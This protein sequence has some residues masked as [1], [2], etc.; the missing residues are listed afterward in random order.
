MSLV[1][2]KDVEVTLTDTL[3]SN[4]NEVYFGNSFDITCVADGG[5]IPSYLKFD[6]TP[7]GSSTASEI[8]LYN[9][10][11]KTP[12]SVAV[13]AEANTLTYVHPVT[14]SD[15]DDDGTYKCLS[16]NRAASEVEKENIKSTDIIV[17][18]CSKHLLIFTNCI[19][20]SIPVSQCEL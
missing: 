17:G 5:R 4:L 9:M 10:P 11:G 18:Q 7:H 3:S 8:V 2:V 12:T 15:Y 1:L 6:R 13:S 19:Y 14:R 16:K 20:C